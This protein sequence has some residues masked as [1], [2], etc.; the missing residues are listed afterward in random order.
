M[1]DAHDL[2]KKRLSSHLK[3]MSKYLRYILNEHIAIA[4]LFFITAIA[5]Y[6]QQWLAQLPADFPSAWIIGIVFGMS[7]SYA[8]VGTL[9]KE[10]DLVFLIPAEHKMKVYFRNGLIYSYV[11][12]LLP[13]LFVS[14]ALSPLYFHAYPNRGGGVYL[15]TLLLLLLFKAWQLVVNWWM[16]KVRDIG[17][18]R[19]DQVVRMLLN[20]VTFILIVKGEIFLAGI[21]TMFLIGIFIYNFNISKKRAGIA[22][23]ILIEKE[24]NRMQLFYRLANLFTDVPHLKNKI[25][26]RSWLVGIVSKLPFVK[27][28]TYDYLYRI[29]FVR[30][31]DYLGMYVRLIIVGGLFIYYVPNIWMKLL[32]ALLFI[33]MSCFQM[34]TLYQHYRTNMWIDL[35][36]V[37]QEVRHRAVTTWLFKLTFFQTMLF[38]ILIIVL[39]FYVEAL[40]LF[41][42]GILFTIVF[43]NYYVKRKLT[44]TTFK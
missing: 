32:F 7:I 38:T 29:T 6:Y 28:H 13:L 37:T 27:K 19:V 36:P 35:Y 21:A 17:M 11:H 5:V 43:V 39:K 42:V 10:A 16:L 1:F 9:L 2:Y 30:S 33:Y 3:E 18:R 40:L 34:M 23:D 31:G 15:L 4:M 41:V 12:Q 44:K 24:Q 26:K 25:K 22:W 8:P 20:S 14:A